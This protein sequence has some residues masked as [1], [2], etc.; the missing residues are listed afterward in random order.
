MF[1]SFII[2]CCARTLRQPC[3]TQKWADPWHEAFAYFQKFSACCMGTPVNIGPSKRFQ[4]VVRP[5]A[6]W[7]AN[8]VKRWQQ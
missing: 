8:S 2:A 1:S 7:N 6:G 3:I 4:L 5:C